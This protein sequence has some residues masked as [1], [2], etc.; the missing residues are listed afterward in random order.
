MREDLQKKF[1]GFSEGARAIL[2]GK[3]EDTVPADAITLFLKQLKVK[4]G[5]TQAIE[6]LLGSAADG[7]Y[8]RD[9]KTVQAIARE[10][11]D[12]QIGRASLL[13][14]PVGSRSSTACTSR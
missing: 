6:L 7:I 8:V 10:L 2:Q 13:A 5:F 3:L 12:K 1:E 4:D 9:A 11:G 14:K